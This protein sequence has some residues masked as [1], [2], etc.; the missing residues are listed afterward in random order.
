MSD[1]WLAIAWN[2]EG[3]G[4]GRLGV[5]GEEPAAAA[6]RG[7]DAEPHMPEVQDGGP[8]AAGDAG[9]A[10]QGDAVQHLPL[11]LLPR[12]AGLLPVQ[13]SFLRLHPAAGDG[14]AARVLRPEGGYHAAE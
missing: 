1:P 7:A 4:P 9:Y 12:R 6:D 5:R 10:S 14:D 11:P 8:Q 3:Y 2:A 13:G